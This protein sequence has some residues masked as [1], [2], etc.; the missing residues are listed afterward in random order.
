MNGWDMSGTMLFAH[1]SGILGEQKQRASLN[2]QIPALS[3]NTQ[4]SSARFSKMDGWMENHSFPPKKYASEKE[5][6]KRAQ[7]LQPTKAA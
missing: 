1:S 4:L 5:G 6:G 7:Q 3:M 2:K